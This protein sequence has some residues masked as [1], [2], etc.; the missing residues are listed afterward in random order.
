MAS[1]G[2][3]ALVGWSC[4]SGCEDLIGICSA[5]QQCDGFGTTAIDSQQQCLIIEHG[6][7]FTFRCGF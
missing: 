2:P 5:G 6:C 4:V 3:T 1:I 7:V